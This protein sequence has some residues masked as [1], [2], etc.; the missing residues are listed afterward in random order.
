MAESGGEGLEKLKKDNLTSNHFDDKKSIQRFLGTDDFRITPL[1]GDASNRNYFRVITANKNYILMQSHDESSNKNFVT[2]LNIL[3][4]AKVN[5]PKLFK[6]QNLFMLEDLGDLTL[7]QLFFKEKKEAVITM[8]KKAVDQLIQLQKVQSDL[9]IT[10]DTKKIFEELMF[11]N[12][13]FV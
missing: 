10:F 3:K 8:Y 7:E 5:V 2:I 12:T 6:H 11:L 4:T 9:N 13:S 1:A